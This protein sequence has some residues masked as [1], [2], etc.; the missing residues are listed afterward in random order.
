MFQYSKNNSYQYTNNKRIIS[1]YKF[2]MSFPCKY[3]VLNFVYLFLL[4][5]WCL[6]INKMYLNPWKEV[7]VILFYILIMCLFKCVILYICIYESSKI[8][9]KMY[10]MWLYSA[11]LLSCYLKTSCV[12]LNLLIII[13]LMP[14]TCLY[15]VMFCS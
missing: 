3:E 6:I 5:S 13:I 10:L 2:K 9:W 4:I 14:W 15:F 7:P 12:T 11:W 1:Y 8:W